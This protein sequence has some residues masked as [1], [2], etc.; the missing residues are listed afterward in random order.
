VL[1]HPGS[2]GLTINLPHGGGA[3]IGGANIRDRFLKLFAMRSERRRRAFMAKAIDQFHA[4]VSRLLKG[5][6]RHRM[7]G[8]S[9]VEVAPRALAVIS[10]GPGRESLREV[11]H[12]AG[13]KLAVAGNSASAI[14]KQKKDHFPII[15]YERELAERDWRQAVSIFSRLS[16]RPCVILLS[17]NSDK[18]LW[19]ELVRCGG[20]DLLRTPVD[21][22][23]MI[24]TLRAG[25]SIWQNQH[26][27]QNLGATIRP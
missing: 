21:R 9:L 22:D 17:R 20:F 13:W 27:P 15:L 6:P 24:R 10:E 16:P 25:W 26:I 23:T 18:N 11:F 5:A 14:A 2:V 4:L 1:Y 3:T 12:E 8:R 7:S 19:D